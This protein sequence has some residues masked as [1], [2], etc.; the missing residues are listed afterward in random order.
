[1]ENLLKALKG[2]L[3]LSML[4]NILDLLLIKRLLM[5]LDVHLLNGLSLKGPLKQ[6]RYLRGMWDM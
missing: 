3:Y 1:M 5:S 4:H 2:L 6:I